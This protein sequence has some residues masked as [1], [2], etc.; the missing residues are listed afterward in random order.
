M[1]INKHTVWGRVPNTKG[2]GIYWVSIDGDLFSMPYID[3]S[4]KTR[5]LR[6]LNVPI[7]DKGYI[8]VT[9][10]NIKQAG[11]HR[12]MMITFLPKGIKE[13]VN[14]LN[15]IKTDNRVENLEWCTC[16]ENLQHAFKMGLMN[17]VKGERCGRSK[18]KPNQVIDILN[19][20][21]KISEL[22]AK[23][24]VNPYLIYAIMIV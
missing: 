1:L 15:G 23:Y 13:E 24:N 16:K 14:H 8:L 2:R 20:T 10:R 18:L 7:S 9:S 4:G 11:L 21:K 3:Q 19:S 17:H 6:R 12:V 22:A 5:Y